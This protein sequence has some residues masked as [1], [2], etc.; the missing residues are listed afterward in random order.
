MKRLTKILTAAGITVLLMVPAQQ[1]FGWWG[2]PWHGSGW[3]HGYAYDPAYRW[4]SPATRQYI[5]DLHLF[6]P[7]YAQWRRARRWWW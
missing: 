7:A 3:R 2:G 6:G 4:G 1:A 5:R